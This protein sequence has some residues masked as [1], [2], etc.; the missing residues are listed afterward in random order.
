MLGILDT[1]LKA[2]TGGEATG[3]AFNVRVIPDLFTG[4]CFNIGVAG[5]AADGTRYIKVIEEVGRL[6]CLYG[7]TAENVLFLAELAADAFMAGR[8]APSPNII[9]DKPTP[10]WNNTLQRTIA[11]LF[12]D[13]VTVA[14]PMRQEDEPMDAPDSDRVRASI[15]DMLR[16]KGPT[17][18]VDKLIPQSPMVVVNTS[19]GPKTVKIPLQAD[20]AIG[21]IESAAYSPQTVRMHLMDAM[22][23]LEFAADAWQM[24]RTGIFIA[25]PVLAKKHEPRL[26]Q[27]DAAIEHVVSRAPR[28]CHVAIES[29]LDALTDEILNWA[30]LKKA[31]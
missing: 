11:Q 21:G 5:I 15:Y 28:T 13:Q 30:E 12:A 29:D 2:P 25:R 22:I 17:G 6:E 20:T 9:F 16:L 10:F 4:E 7:K 26:R 27:I 31:A 1:L 3:Q 24:T 18:L 23:N 14:I 19:R 8:E